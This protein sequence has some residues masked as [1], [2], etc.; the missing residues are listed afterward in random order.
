[1]TRQDAGGHGDRLFIAL[2]FDEETKDRLCGAAEY[3]AAHMRGGHTTGRENLHL[4]LAFLG[5]TERGAEV[6]RAMKEAEGPAFDY[7]IRG[8]GRFLRGDGSVFWAGIAAPEELY[9]LYGRLC[10]ALAEHGFRP[11]ERPFKPHLTL[12]REVVTDETFDPK[13]MEKLLP[14][15]PLHAGK[16]SLMKSERIAGKLTYT[17]IYSVSLEEKE[18]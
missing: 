10:A 8:S 12:G 15:K 18:G 13:E 6:C 4:T 14:E 7:K 17:E 2:L 1:M 16:I 5:E 9:R 11:E 3:L